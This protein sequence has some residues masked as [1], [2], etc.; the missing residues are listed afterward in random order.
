MNEPDLTF[1]TFMNDLYDDSTKSTFVQYIG[2]FLGKLHAAGGTKSANNQYAYRDFMAC[3][4]RA[5][6]INY[7]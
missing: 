6:C 7:L 5:M 4:R 2:T 1:P 3:M